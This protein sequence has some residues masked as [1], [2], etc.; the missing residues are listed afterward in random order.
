M[1]KE[2]LKILLNRCIADAGQLDFTRCDLERMAQDPASTIA[3]YLAEW[4]SQGFIEVTQPIESA[5]SD[6][7]C[8]HVHDYIE[9][10]PFA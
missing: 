3:T 8:I 7:L 9:R 1:P 5:T 4:Q 2:R 10:S 6:Q